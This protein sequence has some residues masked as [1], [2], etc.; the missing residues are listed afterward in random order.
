[1][2]PVAHHLLLITTLKALQA[3]GNDAIIDVDSISALKNYIQS[4]LT[5]PFL[6]IAVLAKAVARLLKYPQMSTELTDC[7]ADHIV[8]MLSRL[9]QDKLIRRYYSSIILSLLRT[10]CSQPV[11]VTQLMQHDIASHLQTLMEVSSEAEA[12]VIAGILWKL[13]DVEDN[14]EIIIDFK[15]IQ[16][17]FTCNLKV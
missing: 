9:S 4:L 11:N 8:A 3:P 2:S 10:L 5:S 13:V 7:E 17:K 14:V 15:A 12:E 16:S 1:M 6:L